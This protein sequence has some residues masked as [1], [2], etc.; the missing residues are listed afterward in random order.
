MKKHFGTRKLYTMDRPKSGISEAF[1]ILRT[2]LMYTSVDKPIKSILMASS[3]P[4]EGKSVI[5][6]NLA[7]VM[8]QTGK[9]VLL[10]DCDLRKPVQ[11][12]IFNL[13]RD[14][15]MTNCLA[16]YCTWEEA[17]QHTAVPNLSILAS[18]PVPPNPAE[19]LGSKSMEAF[20]DAV[21]GE[22]DLVLVDAPPLM[23]VTDPAI[24]ATKCDG[25]ILVTRAGFTKTGAVK[26]SLDA[27]IKAG[28]NIL[29]AVLNDVNMESRYYAKRYGRYYKEYAH[30]YYVEK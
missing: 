1:R 21:S 2:N 11:N 5:A 7:V 25:V 30:D 24:L 9:K 19:L 27:L 29:G 23:A 8:A 3:N 16:G 12:E 18:G 6:A 20:L 17:L 4:Q 26:E 10:M 28:A 14:P 13:N 15:G 22:F